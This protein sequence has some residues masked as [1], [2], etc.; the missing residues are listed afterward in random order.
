MPTNSAAIVCRELPG[1]ML[2]EVVQTGEGSFALLPE[3][4]G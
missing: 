2:E 1:P 3:D 4:S